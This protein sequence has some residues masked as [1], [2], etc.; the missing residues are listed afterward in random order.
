MVAPRRFL[1]S[2]NLL[3]AF[4]AVARTKSVSAAARELSL[5]QS[6]VSK[7][8]QN[9]EQLLGVE[10]FT[11]EK[12]RL[13][14]NL[15]GEAY[16]R[17]IR[18][19]LQQISQGSL[20]LKANPTGGSLNLAILPSFGARWLA[21]RLDDFL[22]KNSGITVNLST[23][24]VP[25][26]FQ[27]EQLDAAIHYGD[28]NWPHSNS[29]KLMDETVVPVCA[30]AFFHAANINSA[31]DM[32]QHPLLHLETRPNAWELWM[33]A[34]Q[35]AAPPVTGRL[36]DQFE[37]MKEVAARGIGI[38]LLPHFMAAA[39]LT[40]GRLVVAFGQPISNG[41]A[42]YLVWPQE[43]DSHPPLVRFRN[44]LQ[45]SVLPAAEKE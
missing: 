5:T 39:E 10:L 26:D 38:A 41:G 3:M 23:R 28:A 27:S 30:P 21:P 16:A 1:P 35:V 20:K 9:L 40:S 6:A 25:F 17:T 45:Q 31:A 2:I 12:R 44:W 24:L 7:Q 37:T 4:E 33:A 29:L 32:V 18:D 42:Y 22:S 8:V 14:V 19:A 34:H 11:R 13:V 36:F 15:A 43:N